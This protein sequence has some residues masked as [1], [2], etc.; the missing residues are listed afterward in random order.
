MKIIIA[1]LIFGHFIFARVNG[2]EVLDFS[3]GMGPR[4]CGFK[5]FGT[6][7]SLRLLPIGGLCMMLG[8]D[9]DQNMDNEHSFYAKNVWQRVSVLVAGP[10]FNFILAFFLIPCY[11][12]HNKCLIVSVPV[13]KEEYYEGLPRIIDE[14]R[15]E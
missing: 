6:Q 7:F 11:N 3:I 14:L 4:L 15:L 9:Q 5:A 8:E 13:K 1:I 12:V 10:G 2:I